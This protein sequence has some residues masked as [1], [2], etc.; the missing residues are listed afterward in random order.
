MKYK[1]PITKIR[2]TFHEN[3][4]IRRVAWTAW[5]LRAS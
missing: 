1:I 4:I 3:Y 2:T 5:W